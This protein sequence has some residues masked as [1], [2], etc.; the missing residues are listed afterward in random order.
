LVVRFIFFLCG[1]AVAAV[2]LPTTYATLSDAQAKLFPGA[3]AFSHSVE[4]NNQQRARIQNKL[5]L[6]IPTG[7][8]VIYEFKKDGQLVG[9][10][11]AVH[12]IGKTEPITFF[13][14]VNPKFKIHGI[15]VM[16]YRE[17]YGSAVRKRRFLSQFLGKSINDPLMVNHD[18]ASISGATLS[19]V[20][21]ANGGREVLQIVHEV[22]A[23]SNA[24]L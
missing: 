15:T 19:A 22:Y 4:L 5:H 16:V 14:A 10:G 6:K 7:N 23:G 9:W 11:M 1:F 12:R 2:A 13:V 20:A 3:K 8:P 17:A 24:H 18:I 21:I